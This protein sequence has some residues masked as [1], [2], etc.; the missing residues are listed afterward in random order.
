MF[1]IKMVS[2]CKSVDCPSSQKLLDFQTGRLPV[3][4]SRDA[5][6][7]LADCEFCS[8]EVEFYSRY[9]QAE[10]KQLTVEIPLPLYELAEALL[11]NKHKDVRML[12]KLLAE[13]DALLEKA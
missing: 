13:P 2:F 12:N 10:E 4:E 6:S 8:A 7:H 5:R 11:S 1:S 3:K 9:P